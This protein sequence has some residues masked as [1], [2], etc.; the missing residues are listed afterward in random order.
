M[1]ALCGANEGRA[2]SASGTDY[3][4]DAA[5]P[6]NASGRDCSGRA[7]SEQKGAVV[8]SAWHKFS[9]KPRN[10]VTHRIRSGL[11]VVA[12]ATASA[13]TAAHAAMLTP[14]PT[15]T[16]GRPLAPARRVVIISSRTDDAPVRATK[17]LAEPATAVVD[18]VLEGRR[19]PGV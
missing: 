8:R 2:A 9:G 14:A 16:S 13:E 5:D 15:S 17:R 12:P 3:R 18:K 4:A 6:A 10:D 19:Q 1:A 11:A 7:D